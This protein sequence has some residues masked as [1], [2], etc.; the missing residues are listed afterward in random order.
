VDAATDDEQVEGGVGE[1]GEIAD[2]E[3]S[4]AGSD[5]AEPVPIDGTY[6]IVGPCLTRRPPIPR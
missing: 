2:H 3:G 6:L 5:T 1:A 4:G